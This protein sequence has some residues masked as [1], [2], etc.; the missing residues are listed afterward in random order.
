MKHAR[1]DYN[2]IQDP[3]NLIPNDEPIFLI[4]GQDEAAPATLR[5]Y[6]MR[7]AQSGAARNI[8][9]ATLNHADQMEE[10]QKLR[11]RKTPDMPS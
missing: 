3:E 2:R 9:E 5:Y 6:A 4:R 8:I 7:A 1:P 10:W 11:R